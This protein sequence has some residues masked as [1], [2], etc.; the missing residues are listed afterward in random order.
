MYGLYLAVNYDYAF[1]NALLVLSFAFLLHFFRASVVMK[2]VYCQLD[3][4][5]YY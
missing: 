2:R 4:L 1:V 5:D 3:G